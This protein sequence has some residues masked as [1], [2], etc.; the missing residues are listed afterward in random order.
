VKIVAA[1]VAVV[2]GF[3]GCRFLRSS[4]ALGFGWS[5]GRAAQKLM[6]P[7]AISAGGKKLASV[8]LVAVLGTELRQK[9]TL[10]LV[11]SVTSWLT[12][13]EIEVVAVA[14]PVQS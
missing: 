6:L 1:A 7:L 4:R 3:D 8:L 10:L 13:A 12:A 11:C 14:G 9:L 2:H 5:A